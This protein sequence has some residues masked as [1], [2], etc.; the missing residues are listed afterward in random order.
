M[1]PQ[2]MRNSFLGRPAKRV[3]ARVELFNAKASFLEDAPDFVLELAALATATHGPQ[4]PLTLPEQA[5]APWLIL[6]DSAGHP[7]RLTELS[8]D[9]AIN[10]VVAGRQLRKRLFGPS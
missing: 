8:G 5:K 3:L 1:R 9:I 10:L 2:N 7:G 6:V 4:W